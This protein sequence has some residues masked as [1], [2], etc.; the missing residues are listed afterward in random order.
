M[1]LFINEAWYAV[2]VVF[3]VMSV[4]TGVGAVTVTDYLHVLS[5]RSKKLE[6]SLVH[7]YPL[8]GKLIV[9][10]LIGI[11][12][13]GTILVL[14]KPEVLASELFRLKLILVG[15][16]TINGII[17]HKYVLP[18]IDKSQEKIYPVVFASLSIVAW[19]SVLTLSITKQL[20]YTWVQAVIFIVIMFF[21]TF[22]TAL[23]ME[24]HFKA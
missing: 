21:L 17:L 12:I 24:R 8:L 1:V 14:K 19:Y 9:L 7:V 10:S 22:F 23:Y 3:H 6:K 5:L 11:Y 13:T 2:A 18:N 4:L 15:I 16:V 20:A